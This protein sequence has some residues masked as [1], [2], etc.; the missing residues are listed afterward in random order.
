MW[1]RRQA[2]GIPVLVAN[3][4]FAF[5]P[6]VARG[7]QPWAG[8]FNRFGIGQASR[9]L[10]KSAWYSTE[11]S[12]E[13]AKTVKISMHEQLP[14]NTKLGRK[15]VSGEWWSGEWK[16][17]FQDYSSDNHSDF[18]ASLPPPSSFGGGLPRRESCAFSRQFNQST[19]P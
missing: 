15:T 14:Q 13:P 10:P 2:G 9:D 6:R 8:C 18:S 11:K 5:S 16:N 12:E 1:G 17:S 3:S 7:A 19:Y 4:L